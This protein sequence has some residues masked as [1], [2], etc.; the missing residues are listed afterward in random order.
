MLPVLLGVTFLTFAMMAMLTGDTIDMISQNTGGYLSPE[1]MAQMRQE[2]GL[3]QPF[4]IQYITWL[5]KV[6]R[7]DFGVS[8]LSGKD[9][10]A[11]F[12][13]KLPATLGLAA[14][15]L[16][17]TVSIS[18]PAGIL[19]AVQKDRLA[20]RLLS[21]VSFVGSSTPNFLL[22]L[23]L[24]LLFS[25]KLNWFSAIGG[26]GITD[27]ILPA[28]S[29]IIVMTSK[30]IRQVRGIVL[31]ELDKEYVKAAKLRG[32]PQAVVI[33]KSVLKSIAAPLITM[34]ALSLGSLLGGTAIVETIFLWDGIGKLAVESIMMRDYPMIQAYVIWISIIY[35]IINL[36]ADL[37]VYRLD[38]RT[39]AAM[40]DVS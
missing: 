7:G 19:A 29:L 15:A 11:V 22:S 30:Y 40:E 23:L 18:V 31:E 38:P 12:C 36:I 28:L 24:I 9:V 37:L 3:D 21:I 39:R 6:I 34:F 17:V 2:R 27:I 33:K 14:L 35:G 5:G 10:L 13:A 32:I 16:F 20:D 26:T 8:Y 25:V 4:L 1:L